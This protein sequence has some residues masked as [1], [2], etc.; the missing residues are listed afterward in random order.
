MNLWLNKYHRYSQRKNNIL[1][2]IFVEYMTEFISLIYKEF[3]Q[4][5]KKKRNNPKE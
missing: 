4:I 2:N 3:I 5:I 1:E